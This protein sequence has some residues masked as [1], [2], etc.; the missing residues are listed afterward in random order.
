MPPASEGPDVQEGLPWAPR[1]WSDTLIPVLTALSP[2]TLQGLISDPDPAQRHAAERSFHDRGD[3]CWNSPVEAHS[4]TDGTAKGAD[5]EP[6]IPSRKHLCVFKGGTEGCMGAGQKGQDGRRDCQ[7]KTRVPTCHRACGKSLVL[8]G[9][10]SPHL[11]TEE[12]ELDQGSPTQMPGEGPA[13]TQPPEVAKR[14]WGSRARRLA[15]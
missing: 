2:P 14:T 10:Q 6:P 9:P 15:L 7:P 13:G 5:G 11:Y 3:K 12:C 1:R 4:L 8:S